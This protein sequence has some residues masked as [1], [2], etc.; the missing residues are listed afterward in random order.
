MLYGHH[1]WMRII[2][3]VCHDAQ[4][5]L[6]SS[7]KASMA[8]SLRQAARVEQSGRLTACLPLW[9]LRLEGLAIKEKRCRVLR[10]SIGA[11]EA[12]T[13]HAQFLRQRPP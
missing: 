8:A 10:V 11:V 5:R 4:T 6:A 3:G 1:I 9:R 7:S 12:C 13:G 2:I